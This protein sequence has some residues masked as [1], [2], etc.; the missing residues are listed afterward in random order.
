MQNKRLQTYD[1]AV[2]EDVEP[3]FASPRE[4]SNFAYRFSRH[5]FSIA[6]DE[7][8]SKEESFIKIYE[9]FLTARSRLC[10][11]AHVEQGGNSSD[12]DD[13]AYLTTMGFPRTLMCILW[14]K[15][16]ESKFYA[17]QWRKN[18]RRDKAYKVSFKIR[19]L[20]YCGRL[21][22][23]INLH[24]K[25]Q[26]SFRYKYSA[27]SIAELEQVK[28]E[29]DPSNTGILTW[30]V[31]NNKPSP[32]ARYVKQMALDVVRALLEER[33]FD[34]KFPLRTRISENVSRLNIVGD[35]DDK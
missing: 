11:Q 35:N 1:F 14:H 17:R 13:V 24:N 34:A 26:Y 2:Y 33:Q 22:D 8:D 23:E 20:N 5:I 12:D 31:K 19:K 6:D 10:C 16:S 25:I 7:F 32:L 29:I 3:Y 28:K 30:H 21:A 9:N 15:M 4:M 18:A 27:L